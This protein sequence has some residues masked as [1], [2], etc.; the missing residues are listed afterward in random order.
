MFE[1]DVAGNLK[2]KG[3]YLV[4]QKKKIECLM[5]LKSL[6]DRVKEDY[7]LAKKRII[8]RLQDNVKFL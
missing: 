1:D 3:E 7:E 8:F 2:K 5:G 6:R 4:D